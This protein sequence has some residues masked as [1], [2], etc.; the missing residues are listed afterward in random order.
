MQ[1]QE[2]GDETREEITLGFGKDAR[3][4]CPTRAARAPP[5]RTSRRRRHTSTARHGCA[6]S[7]AAPAPAAYGS[8]NGTVSTQTTTAAATSW[9]QSPRCAPQAAPPDLPHDVRGHER[10]RRTSGSSVQDRFCATSAA[11]APSS[12]R[13]RPHASSVRRRVEVPAESVQRERH[14]LRRQHLQV[15]SLRKP[16]RREREEQ[17]GDERRARRCR[18]ARARTGTCR[19]PDSTNVE[20]NSRL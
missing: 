3:D 15:A 14:P 6:R 12:G 18:S 20:R 10:R 16:V 8:R 9:I 4:R 2:H 17:A 1:R 11:V 13:Q 19:G 5:S 7:A